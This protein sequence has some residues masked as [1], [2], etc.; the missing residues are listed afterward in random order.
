MSITS[1]NEWRIKIGGYE[2]LGYELARKA[3]LE[4]LPWPYLLRQL[5]FRPYI[6]AL[7]QIYNP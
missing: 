2:T 6:R 5:W 3:G 4:Q 1:A 7:H